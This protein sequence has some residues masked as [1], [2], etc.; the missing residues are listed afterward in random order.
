LASAVAQSKSFRRPSI[1]TADCLFGRVQTFSFPGV[2]KLSWQSLVWIALSFS[3]IIVVKV[4][5]QS[6]ILL[7]NRKRITTLTGMA[8]PPKNPDAV[9]GKDLRIPVTTD[10]RELIRK[11]TEL[12]GVDMAAWARPL[13]VK[14]AEEILAQQPS[15]KRRS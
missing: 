3:A 14:A 7:T 1:E 12:T 5:L 6:S 4:L 10:Q 9:L 15:R 8:R 11:A 2:H 13:L